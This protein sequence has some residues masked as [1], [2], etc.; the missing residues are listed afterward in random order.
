MPKPLL[1]LLI[2]DSEAD[3]LLLILELERGDYQP[4]YCRVDT[5]VG[6]RSVLETQKWDVIL[7]DYSMPQF[8]VTD[9]LQ[10]LQDSSLDVPFII[11][12]GSIGEEVA[13]AAMKAGAHDYL[14][15]DNL[16]RLVATVER[17]I[18]E[19]HVRAERQQAFETIRYLAFH[20][21]LT[22]LP[23]RTSFLNALQQCLEQTSEQSMAF[24]VLLVD[25]NRY[26]T[27]KYSLGHLIGEQFLLATAQKLQGC[28][29]SASLLARV[30]T[31]EFAILLKHISSDQESDQS[32]AFSSTR[33]S[34]AKFCDRIHQALTDP[35]ELS[36][37]K[38]FAT[39]SIG[40]APSTL[41]HTQAEAFLGAADTA[42]HYAKL[43][44]KSETAWFTA[45]MQA[46]VLAR[47]ELETDLQHAIQQQRQSAHGQAFNGTQL[48]LN[49]QPIVN[50]AQPQ[51]LA[52]EALA[53]WHHPQRGQISPV[54][55][56]PIAEET[57]LITD[58]GQWVLEE[59]CHQLSCWKQHS[60][61]SLPRISVNLS[62][63]QLSQR[64]F[65]TV[66]DESLDR[67]GLEGSD[68]ELEITESVLMENATV[69]TPLLTQLKDRGIQISIDDFGTGYSSLSYLTKLPIDAVKIDRS[70]I[71]GMVTSDQQFDIVKAIV[72]MAH[73][74]KLVVVAEG[75]ETQGQVAQLRSLGCESGQGYL[76]SRPLTP[77]AVTR[78]LNDSV[79]LDKVLNSGQP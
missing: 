29:N 59:A 46:Q 58:L 55:F 68:L 27:I 51:L 41:E 26:Q 32:D 37:S 33:A 75:I 18:R 79:G 12:S 64:Q 24:A 49:Y 52:V 11:V 13:V 30:G 47:L 39:C 63:K 70:F 43:R 50:L 15:K 67:F 42:K 17:E 23:N 54:E 34:I 73:T 2:E 28:L 5:P 76:F 62:A 3:A 65:M 78:L 35:F 6:M 21:S 19:A 20:D 10:I 36:N 45:E 14:L 1:V 61:C 31:D 40:V 8:N 48:S 66:L 25:I 38:I 57:G 22:G 7:A 16:T 69:A 77:I 74:L 71:Q 44:G 4:S 53:R 72:G 56:I 60:P 9:A